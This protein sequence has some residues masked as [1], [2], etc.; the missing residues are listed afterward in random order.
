[1]WQIYITILILLFVWLYWL[2]KSHIKIIEPVPIPKDVLVYKVSTP[3]YSELNRATQFHVNGHTMFDENINDTEIPLYMMFEHADIEYYNEPFTQIEFDDFLHQVRNNNDNDLYFRDAQNVHDTQIQKY[4]R[5]ENAE[6]DYEVPV[7]TNNKKDIY[8]DLMRDCPDHLKNKVE[9]VLNHIKNNDEH[10][11]NV[12]KNI[13]DL[14]YQISEKGKQDKNIK[15]DLYKNIADCVENDQ[16]VC[17]TGIS[18]RL[19]SSLYINNPEEAPKTRELIH[20][21]MMNLSSKVQQDNPTLDGKELQNTILNKLNKHY[22]GILT[23][24]EVNEYTKDWIEHV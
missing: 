19:T 14:L 1:M 15:E 17:A 6:L 2:T 13:S 24:D 8:A 10:I 7:N 20:Q 12:D 22:E 16:V 4:I 18:T 11:A 3:F 23:K 21:E 9:Q 5:K